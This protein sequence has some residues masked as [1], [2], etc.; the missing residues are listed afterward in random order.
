MRGGA[1]A[2]L[3]VRVIAEYTDTYCVSRPEQQLGAE[4]FYIRGVLAF[5]GK[6]VIRIAV[7]VM[8]QTGDAQCG[9]FTDGGIQRALYPDGAFIAAADV[10]IAAQFISGFLLRK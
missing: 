7:I 2:G 6:T 3:I 8:E 5:T 1:A 9:A 4:G 10:N